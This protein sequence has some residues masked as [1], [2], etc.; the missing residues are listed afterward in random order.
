MASPNL[1]SARRGEVDHTWLALVAFGTSLA[2]DQLLQGSAIS[3]SLDDDD[4]GFN[5]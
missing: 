3:L 2:D 1:L 4:D 5:H